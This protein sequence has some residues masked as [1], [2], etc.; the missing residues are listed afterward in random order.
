MKILRLSNLYKSCNN[1]YQAFKDQVNEG[2]LLEGIDNLPSINDDEAYNLAQSVWKEISLENKSHEEA[3][4]SF[5]E[6]LELIKSRAKGF[7]FEVAK[8]YSQAATGTQDGEETS[9][10]EL[11]GVVWM[12]G[13][14]RRNIELFGSYMS[15]D[16]M[17]RG[18]NTLLWPYV[19]LSLMD[20]FGELCIGCEGIV[21]GE[22]EEMYSFMIQFIAK[23]CPGRS[24]AEVQI[25]SAD[26]FFTPKFVR[27][28]G[29][30]NAVY[31]IDRWHL[32]SSGLDDIFGKQGADYLRGHLIQMIDANSEAQFDSVVVSA[33]ELLSTLSPRDE[34]LETKF[35]DFVAMKHNYS[36]YLIRSLPGNRGRLGSVF[37]EI[38]H[39]S[40]LTYLNEG[41]K[42][43]NKYCEYPVTLIRD[44]LKRQQKHCRM[45]NVKLLGWNQ[46]MEIERANLQLEVETTM[47]NDLIHAASELNYG[48]YQQ[49]K[50]FQLRAHTDLCKVVDNTTTGGP[51]TRIMSKRYP[52]AP[53]RIFSSS[54]QRCSCEDRIRDDSQCAHEIC[55]YGG[56]QT[57]LHRDWHMSRQQVTASILGWDPPGDSAI[58]EILGYDGELVDVGQSDPAI[59]NGILGM[60]DD[61][62]DDDDITPNEGVEL[63]N[64]PREPVPGFLPETDTSMRA[65]DMRKIDQVFNSLKHGYSRFDAEKKRTVGVLILQL[66]KAVKSRTPTFGTGPNANARIEKPSTQVMRREPKKRRM[67]QKEKELRNRTKKMKSMELQNAGITVTHVRGDTSIN[68][69][70]RTSR[71]TTCGFCKSTEHRIEACSKRDRLKLRSHEYALTLDNLEAELSLKNQMTSPAMIN[72]D[73]GKGEPVGSVSAD[74]RRSNI[75]INEISLVRGGRRRVIEDMLFHVTFLTKHGDEGQRMW[76][77]GHLFNSLISHGFKKVKYIYDHTIHPQSHWVSAERIYEEEQMTISQRMTQED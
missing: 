58:D 30:I 3:L 25:V 24:L 17:M 43:S 71:K 66:E 52:D 41:D 2:E 60:A 47:R 33:N 32:T 56:Y 18:I 54:T 5:T 4:F 42:Y 8:E 73:V 62:D 38:N 23:S 11:L 28:L 77:T 61:L 34:A 55:L 22:H 44:L 10:K 65:L 67:P 53:P 19:A 6:Y 39:S 7:S 63:S 46:D 72:P 14:M 35:K 31:I 48:S 21:C 45:K 59:E 36:S 40:V 50:R 29:F 1:D 68:A 76:L 37:S 57:H 13:T 74:L 15:F 70:A 75:V 16:M 12:T 51:T 27:D 9:N 49:Y 26:R 64:I 69:N 20:E